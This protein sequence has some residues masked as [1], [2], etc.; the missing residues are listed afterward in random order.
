MLNVKKFAFLMSRHEK[1]QYINPI[2]PFSHFKIWSP[3]HI[4][5]NPSFIE[6]DFFLVFWL[7]LQWNMRKLQIYSYFWHSINFSC[8]KLYPKSLNLAPKT[9]KQAN[10][11]SETFLRGLAR[12][13]NMCHFASHLFRFHMGYV[14]SWWFLV[15][16]LLM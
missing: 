13:W 7:S 3:S 14:P 16:Y 5:H 2:N 10:L 8:P 12:T 9:L 15:I 4:G 1:C 11:L 6:I